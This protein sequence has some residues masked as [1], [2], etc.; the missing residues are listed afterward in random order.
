MPQGYSSGAA[1]ASSTERWGHLCARFGVS[2]ASPAALSYSSND[3][4]ATGLSRIPKPVCHTP[5]SAVSCRT[6]CLAC[7]LLRGDPAVQIV[8][9]WSGC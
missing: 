4:Q 9:N 1:S 8:G 6:C 7:S 5:S 2:S 3:T